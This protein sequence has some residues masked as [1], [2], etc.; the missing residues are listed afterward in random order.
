MAKKESVNVGAVGHRQYLPR[1]PTGAGEARAS[2][3]T[4]ST[5]I[6]P[7]PQ[8]DANQIRQLRKRLNVSQPVF[9]GMLN[10]SGSTVRAW[11]QGQRRPDGPTLRLLEVADQH[12]HALLSKVVEKALDAEEK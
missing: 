8:Y 7:P 6:K 1:R 4:R 3:M 11:E 10:V 9:A 12:S 5:E 2:F